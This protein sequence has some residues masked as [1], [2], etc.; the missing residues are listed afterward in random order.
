MEAEMKDVET[1]DND[2]LLALKMK[3]ETTSQQKQV[4][5]GIY[6]IQGNSL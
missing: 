2:A 1:S 6:K 4:A 3:P 5:S